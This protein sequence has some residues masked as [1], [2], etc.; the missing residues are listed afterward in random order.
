[1]RRIRFQFWLLLA[2]CLGAPVKA[3][4]EQQNRTNP[5]FRANVLANQLQVRVTDSQGRIVT[6]LEKS[7][8][9]VLEKGEPR[10]I[11][12]FEARENSGVGLAILVDVGSNMNRE[13]IRKAKEMI[14]ELVHLLGSEDEILTGIYAKDVYFLHPL[15]SD[16]KVISEGLWNLPTGGRT[17]KWKRLGNLFVSTAN[18]G[19][20][21]DE[22][23]L[24]LKKTRHADK[25]VLVISAGFG[26]IGLA[27]FDHLR[28]AGAQL[29]AVSMDDTLG[30]V[31]SLG[32]DQAAR[33]SVVKK[34][35]GITFSGE[36]LLSQI[37]ELRKAIKSYYLLGVSRSDPK[38]G[39]ELTVTLP[40]HPDYRV[41]AALRSRGESSFW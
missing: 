38:G 21:I 36:Q 33:R 32:G 13:E 23:L 8:F 12:L 30:S 39:A 28:L 14:F 31:S 40:G 27:T 18:T 10:P 7:D 24:K 29:L 1:M 6:G 9:V 34:T 4:T 17:G 15:T 25:L 41:H 26:N 22:A 35:G 3:Q 19:Y 11:Q 16:R 37:E 2:I 20:A 5:R